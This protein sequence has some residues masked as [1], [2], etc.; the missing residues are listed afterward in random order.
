MSPDGGNLLSEPDV[1]V[2]NFELRLIAFLYIAATRARCPPDDQQIGAQSQSGETQKTLSAD[3]RSF[4][5]C[6][7][8]ARSSFRIPLM[9]AVKGTSA[10]AV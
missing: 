5:R 8:S 4:R 1:E 6:S 7:S 3:E 10:T 2:A 9:V